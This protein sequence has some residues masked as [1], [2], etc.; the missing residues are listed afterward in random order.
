[1]TTDTVAAMLRAALAATIPVAA[2][3]MAA[4]GV[5]A[6]PPGW[7]SAMAGAALVLV[8]FPVS[9]LV[10]RRSTRLGPA[11]TFVLALGLYLAQVVSL[12]VGFTVADAI[13]L[14]D[15]VV[16]RGPLSVTA[17]VCTLAWTSGQIV[18][19]IRA[20]EPLYR[21]DAREVW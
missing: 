16:L 14:L 10:L 12:G 6:G 19:A 4:G 8:V 15:T 1:M 11:R 21:L 13:G 17:I 7:W 20:R 9:L 2:A 3:S 18:G 5:V